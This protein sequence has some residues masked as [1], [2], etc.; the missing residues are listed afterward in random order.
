M[1]ARMERLLVLGGRYAALGLRTAAAAAFARAA[2]AD[3]G[4]AAP[5]R[6]L[7]EL[8]LATGDGRRAR[9]HAEE[10]QKRQPGPAAR[11]LT[12]RALAAAGELGA[13]RFAFS[14]L[15]EAGGLDARQRASAFLGRAEV[16]AR[17]GDG[18]GAGAHLAAA[19]DVLLASDPGRVGAEEARLADELAARSVS[20]G[21]GPDLHAR[22]VELG[23]ASPGPLH[24]LAA[25]ALLAAGQATGAAGIPDAAIEAA[26]DRA[27]ALDPTSRPIRVRL[28]IRLSRRRYRD[29]AARAR[30]I[31]LLEG[32]AAELAAGA[33]D[34]LADEDACLE[35]AR[36]HF[37]LAALYEDD[38]LAR[39]QAEDEYRAGLRLRPRHAPAANNLALLALHAGDAVTARAELERA[40]RADPRSDV[41]WINAARMLDA[42]RPAPSF[43][44]DVA[45]WL[46]A[47][48]P[49]TGAVAGPAAARLA[50]AAAECSTQGVLDAL[51][52]KGHRLKNLLGIAGARVR[53]ARKAAAAPGA[54]GLDGRLAE[55]ERDL[56]A[57]Y[58]EW[59]AHLRT[60]QAEGPRL[61][62]V[63]VN[64]LLVE[65][66]TSATQEGRPPV[67]FSPGGPLPDLRADRALLREALLNL[68]VNAL[69]AQEAGGE[70]DRPVEIV[71]RAVAASGNHAPAV[72]IEIRDRG[73]GIPKADLARIFSPGFTT[74]PQGSGLG[75]AVAHR[76]V[77]AH[78]GRI[79][80]DSE[81]ERGTVMTV[82]LPSDLGG[83]SQLAGPASRAET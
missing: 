29:S 4:A 75:L 79:L 37:L 10:A 76:V 67:K 74:K 13:A 82:V 49:G 21:R 44:E 64:P 50:R 66:V 25:A 1:S 32:L 14:S 16:A 22:A 62:I 47:A 20:L 27:L 40:L 2:A 5:H 11:L 63:P 52:A 80:V 39:P 83:F 46:D 34:P 72:A 31:T 58:D 19:L 55:L 7:A 3:P 69:D 60:L 81:L 15:I 45:A 57:L 71:T 23:G 48:A 38:P 18:A 6:R 68:V 56:G 53:S 43:T 8:F 28:A 73:Q 35:Q 24:E 51:Y 33:D 54:A 65:V 42:A 9:G 26:L 17:E 77:A 12:A 59:A 30:A 41:A 70:L 36:I 78:H 61:E